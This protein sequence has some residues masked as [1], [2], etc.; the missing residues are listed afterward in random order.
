MNGVSPGGSGMAGGSSAALNT[1]SVPPV[2]SPAPHT[3][4]NLPAPAPP[5]PIMTP[6][7]SGGTMATQF[8]PKA[9]SFRFKRASEDMDAEDLN[10]GPSLKQIG[11]TAA[12]GL[13]GGLGAAHLSDLMHQVRTQPMIDPSLQPELADY[14]AGR[15]RDLRSAMLK[16]LAGTAVGAGLGYAA[17]NIHDKLG[18]LF[19]H[20]RGVS[21]GEAEK[22][23]KT[24]LPEGVSL[25]EM[26]GVLDIKTPEG[27]TV[28]LPYR[29]D[30]LDHH[31]DRLGDAEFKALLATH[32]KNLSA[33]ADKEVARMHASALNQYPRVRNTLL[34]GLVGGGI[35]AA[36][37]PG[38]SGSRALIGAGLGAAAAQFLPAT[39]RS[40]PE[41]LYATP[42]G[43]RYPA[44]L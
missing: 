37:G 31:R 14:A 4:S 25:S 2:M 35:G 10:A 16:T 22:V 29:R 33:E 19:M 43:F 27:H 34:G 13:A 8:A 28:R 44:Q 1:P 7:L 15:S 3:S 42:Y 9:A 17:S 39:V 23:A 38:L 18:S 11:M 32:A 12:G 40:G 20:M 36:A 30:N 41:T 5:S 24:D 26:A 21:P 6:N